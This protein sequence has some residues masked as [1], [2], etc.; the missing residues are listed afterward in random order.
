MSEGLYAPRPMRQDDPLGAALARLEVPD[1]GCERRRNSCGCDGPCDCPGRRLFDFGRPCPHVLAA[2]HELTPERW[3]WLLRV[4]DRAGHDDP[5]PPDA[6]AQ[7]LTHAA[8]LELYAARAEAG[9]GLRFPVPRDRRRYA[10][11]RLRH[12]GD[13]V[14][15]E[16]LGGL[17]LGLAPASKRPS[18]LKAAGVVRSWRPSRAELEATAAELGWEAWEIEEVEDRLDASDENDDVLSRCAKAARLRTP[19]P[20]FAPPDEAPAVLPLVR[21]AAAAKP[22]R[23]AA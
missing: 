2:D 21:P 17:D 11:G 20:A 7:A 16:D 8:R 9:V 12:T 1:C 18:D 14:E 13:H 10:D 6:P 22:K 4:F 15:D 3:L 19:P 23:R 5:E